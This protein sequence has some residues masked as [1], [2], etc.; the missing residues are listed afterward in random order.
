MPVG[1]GKAYRS[2]NEGLLLNGS[3]EKTVCEELFIKNPLLIRHQGTRRV[4][5]IYKAALK[6]VKT[7]SVR[8]AEISQTQDARNR[9][10]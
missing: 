2:E 4:S 9:G 8:G 10:G 1:L 7:A 3:E 5:L 6:A